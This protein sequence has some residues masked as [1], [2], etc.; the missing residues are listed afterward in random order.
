MP[1]AAATAASGAKR[2]KKRPAAWTHALPPSKQGVYVAKIHKER[3][4]GRGSASLTISQAAVGEVDRIVDHVTNLL[5]DASKEV[6][7]YTAGTT[8]SEKV[9]SAAGATIFSGDLKRRALE[10]AKAASTAFA[11]AS[12]KSTAPPVAA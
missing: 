10:R 8:L 12:G 4:G 6:L 9:L 7:R 11:A 3:H 1:S 5:C 2:D